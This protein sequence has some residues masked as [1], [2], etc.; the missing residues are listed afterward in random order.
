MQFLALCAGLFEGGS[1][2]LSDPMEGSTL[3]EASTNSFEAMTNGA[4]TASEAPL[5]E[6]Q[7]T[8][9]VVSMVVLQ[10][11]YQ[12]PLHGVKKSLG[13]TSGLRSNNCGSCSLRLLK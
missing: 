12:L 13:T 5:G 7:Q 8:H 10:Q 2:N 11:L 1:G 3:Q 6:Y 9:A 4:S